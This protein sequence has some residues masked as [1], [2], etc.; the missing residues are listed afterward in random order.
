MLEY[1]KEMCGGAG[2]G[3]GMML[4]SG[5]ILVFLIIVVIGAIVG[6]T[7]VQDTAINNQTK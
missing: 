2:S 5:G 1:F 6:V 7:S 3:S 4:L